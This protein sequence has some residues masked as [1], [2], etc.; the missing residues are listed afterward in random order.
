MI[1]LNF[2]HVLFYIELI[3]FQPCPNLPVELD[4]SNNWFEGNL[5]I[6]RD[7]EQLSEYAVSPI[8]TFMT[9]CL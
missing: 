2:V 3:F 1:D 6:L 8:A 5:P 7:F 9:F 4:L